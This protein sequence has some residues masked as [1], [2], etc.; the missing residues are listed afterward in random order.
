MRHLCDK[1]GVL[2]ALVAATAVPCCFPLLAPLG[3]ALGLGALLPFAAYA[4]YGVAVG[5]GVAIVG[6][7]V[8]FRAHRRPGWLLLGVGSGLLVIA[9]LA[10]PWPS[11]L[12]YGGLLGLAVAAVANTICVRRAACPMTPARASAG[13][14]SGQTRRGR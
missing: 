11:G 6:H 2:G 8:A 13:R 4:L 1:V 14:E 7:I 10:F 3:L 9:A 12:V 5:A